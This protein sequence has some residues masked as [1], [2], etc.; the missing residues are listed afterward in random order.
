MSYKVFRGLLQ[1]YGNRNTNIIKNV[2][3]LEVEVNNAKVGYSAKVLQHFC[4]NNQNC[5][6]EKPAAYLFLVD[7]NKLINEF[8]KF[9]EKTREEDLK[10]L[11]KK[12]KKLLKNLKRNFE[13]C[14]KFFDTYH[15]YFPLYVGSTD[16]FSRRYNDFEKSLM[17]GKTAP[18][19]FGGNL[20]QFL[21]KSKLINSQPMK[22][23]LVVFY[24]N[25]PCEAKCIE[26]FILANPNFCAIFNT[27]NN[28]KKTIP[29]N[30]SPIS[31]TFQ[32]IADKIIDAIQKLKSCP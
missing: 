19:V 29:K 26:C 14:N 17:S 7:K 13:N 5:L 18:H 28:S 27:I 3:C 4:L 12:L 24:T 22:M 8:S 1:Q 20:H 30:L 15:F 6:L 16:D 31:Q 25:I 11:E 21:S 10:D 32:Q 23:C 2:C 9:L